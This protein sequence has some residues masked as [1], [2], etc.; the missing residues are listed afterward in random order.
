MQICHKNLPFIYGACV[1]EPQ[2]ISI[3]M[4]LHVFSEGK[5]LNIED[6]LSTKFESP[7]NLDWKYILLGSLSAM[8]YVHSKEVLHKDIKE[9]NFVTERF[10]HK[11]RS[12]LIDLGK[13]CYKSS[14]YQRKNMPR[15]SHRL[16]LKFVM[17]LLLSPARVTCIHL[18]GYFHM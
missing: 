1:K 10:S 4:S 7:V 2:P 9:N 5:V 18:G 16:H 15:N 8:E 14:P 6:A 3:L 17:E 11:F 12:V 13:A